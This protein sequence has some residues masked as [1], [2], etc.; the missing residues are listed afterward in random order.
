MILVEYELFYSSS[1]RVF[2]YE[3]VQY[4]GIFSKSQIGI[5]RK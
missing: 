4:C 1:Q 3:G 2:A 5:F